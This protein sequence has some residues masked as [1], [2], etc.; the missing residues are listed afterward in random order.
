MLFIYFLVA[1]GKDL[2]VEDRGKFPQCQ[3]ASFYSDIDVGDRSKL[4][5]AAVRWGLW[6]SSIIVNSIF[7]IILHEAMGFQTSWVK[8]DAYSDLYEKMEAEE[9]QFAAENWS[10]IYENYSSYVFEYGSVGYE[11]L[12]GLLIP[13]YA[14][15]TSNYDPGLLEVDCGESNCLDRYIIHQLEPVYTHFDEFDSIVYLTKNER[16][17]RDKVVRECGGFSSENVSI[18][19]AIFVPKACEP[20]PRNGSDRAHIQYPEG[21]ETVDI[22]TESGEIIHMN[23]TTHVFPACSVWNEIKTTWHVNVF[24][25]VVVN[26][27]IPARIY[28]WGKCRAEAIVT[29]YINNEIPFLFYWWL[30]DYVLAKWDIDFS[31]VQLAPITDSCYETNSDNLYGHDSPNTCGIEP[32]G[33]LPCYGSNYWSHNAA[34]DARDL[35]ARFFMSTSTLDKLLVYTHSLA[36]NHGVEFTDGTA[37]FQ[38]ACNWVSNHKNIWKAWLPEQQYQLAEVEILNGG[39]STFEMV[40]TI[41]CTIII[42]TLAALYIGNHYKLITMFSDISKELLNKVT[43]EAF[44]ITFLA[45]DITTDWLNYVFTINK[46]NDVSFGF[47]FMYIIFLSMSTVVALRMV[48]HTFNVIYIA[49]FSK[50]ENDARIRLSRQK[51]DQLLRKLSMTSV[52]VGIATLLLEDVPILAMNL[53]FIFDIDKNQSNNIFNIIAMLVTCYSMGLKSFH[54]FMEAKQNFMEADTMR[55]EEMAMTRMAYDSSGSP[56]DVGRFV[57]DSFFQQDNIVFSVGDYIEILRDFKSDSPKRFD[58]KKGMILKVKMVEDGDIRVN[59]AEAEWKYNH[60]VFEKNF[61]NI[62]LLRPD[63]RKYPRNATTPFDPGADLSMLYMNSNSHPSST[64]T[65]HYLL[66]KLITGE[67]H[68]ESHPLSVPKLNLKIHGQ[69]FSKTW[70]RL[71]H[72][73][74]PRDLTSFL[75]CF[76]RKKTGGIQPLFRLMIFSRRRREL[77]FCGPLG[78]SIAAP[79][80]SPNSSWIPLNSK[81][82]SMAQ[83]SRWA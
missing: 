80:R 78:T 12:E 58:F 20:V 51:H 17:L 46:S 21:F 55:S 38:S 19:D 9:I 77:R 54:I 42:F 71:L 82:A 67:N 15:N 74:H 3:P 45:L 83:S 33:A 76:L 50:Q 29:H 22:Q 35:F 62:H 69:A 61:K 44:T 53:L 41:V 49:F 68:H 30:P 79:W 70:R 75:K 14:L 23:T 1:S 24:Q 36:D 59:T 18:P 52:K 60:W 13:S 40:M 4:G 11:G 39:L 56:R 8:S 48:Y 32:L 73:C 31:V 47:V 81:S 28:W 64:S 63:D 37:H 26:L 16:G 2:D 72:I 57:L 6:D 5:N 7:G 66:P 65:T 34:Q 43:A 10:A 25:S 27:N